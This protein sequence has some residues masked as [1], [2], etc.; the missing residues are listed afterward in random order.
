M[1]EKVDRVT[2]IFVSCFFASYVMSIIGVMIGFFSLFDGVTLFEVGATG[3]FGV[4]ALVGFA[5]VEGIKEE[6]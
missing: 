5:F 3:I 1:G 6:Y 2:L 4:M